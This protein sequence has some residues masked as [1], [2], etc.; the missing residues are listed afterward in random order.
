MGSGFSFNAPIKVVTEKSSYQMPEAAIGYFADAGSHY[1][2]PRIEHKEFGLYLALQGARIFGKDI[3]KS[4]IA[5]HFV[6]SDKI[7]DLK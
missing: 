1:Y 5:T 3:V 6:P 7:D 2:L 4:G